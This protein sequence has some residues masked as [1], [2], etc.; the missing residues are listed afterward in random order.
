MTAVAMPLTEA[1][2]AARWGAGEFVGR[3]QRTAAG[4]A[5]M[6]LFAGR[7][8]GPSGP[9]FRDAVLARPDGARLYGDVELHLR[10]R[11]WQA[12]GNA[13]DPHDARVVL[14]VVARADGAQATRLVSG[15]WAAL[16]ELGVAPAPPHTGAASASV[17]PWPCAEPGRS[18]SP[19]E[20]A[21]LLQQAGRERFAQHTA[22]FVEQLATAEQRDAGSGWRAADRVLFAALAEGLTYGRDRAAL[23]RAGEWLAS[24]GAPEALLRQMPRLP[25]LDATRLE[26][27]LTLR[28]H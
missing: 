19:P 2:L 18:L 25:V 11:G 24:G 12:H 15:Q 13:S 16:V 21:G 22:A 9:D 14:H 1:A 27:L 5:L 4:D 28:A 17:P 3:W 23:R 7:P 8:G 6:V 10:A 26:G 20:L